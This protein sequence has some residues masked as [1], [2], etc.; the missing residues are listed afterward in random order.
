MNLLFIALASTR[1]D[2]DQIETREID[3]EAERRFYFISSHVDYGQVSLGLV[4]LGLISAIN[5]WTK[6]SAVM[7]TPTAT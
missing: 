4:S 6:V 7:N 5:D 2:R 3:L 1:K